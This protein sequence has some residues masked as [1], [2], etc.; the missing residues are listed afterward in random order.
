MVDRSVLTEIE[1]T[2]EMIEAGVG[3]LLEYTINLDDP[4]EVVRSVLASALSAS[5]VRVVQKN[6]SADLRGMEIP[7][8]G[9][10][11]C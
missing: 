4:S 1:I 11:S 3:R 5:S 2:P 7:L 9:A 8:D 6:T 10:I